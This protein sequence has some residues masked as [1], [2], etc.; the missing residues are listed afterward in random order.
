MSK[1]LRRSPL[2]LALGSWLSLLASGVIMYLPGM[3]TGSANSTTVAFGTVGALTI[4][5]ALAAVFLGVVFLIRGIERTAA[6]AGI[7][8]G[9]PQTGIVILALLGLWS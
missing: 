3:Q 9:V 2:W 5:L 8:L 1:L 6:L 7:V 4:L